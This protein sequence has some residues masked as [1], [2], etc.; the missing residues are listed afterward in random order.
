MNTISTRTLVIPFKIQSSYR[1]ISV[2]IFN[3]FFRIEKIIKKNVL[4]LLIVFCMITSNLSF[5][6]ESD[7]KK[8]I[9]NITSPF[10]EKNYNDSSTVFGGV[11]RKFTIVQFGSDLLILSYPHFSAFRNRLNLKNYVFW[12]EWWYKDNWGVKSFYSEQ[13]YK[14]FGPSGNRPTS[15]SNHLGMMLKTQHSLSES[16]KIS[17][18]I[19]LSKTEFVLNSQ[20]K[21][22]NS[23]VGEFRMGTEISDDFWF[24]FGMLSIDSASGN[25]IQDQRIGSTGYLVG[26]S[27]GI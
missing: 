10:T 7:K 12:G 17:A 4:L 18:G 24:E 26:F 15:S 22:G 1:D 19:G 25:G 13:F 16:W 9:K 21:L 27:F 20:R 3:D 23:L 6:D 5:A 14:M 2:V 11:G 8:K